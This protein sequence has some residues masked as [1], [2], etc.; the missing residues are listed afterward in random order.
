MAEAAST[1]PDPRTAPRP[2]RG[3]ARAAARHPPVPGLAVG[4]QCASG[5]EAVNLAARLVQDASE[6][7]FFRDNALVRGRGLRFYAGVPLMSATGPRLS[8]ELRRHV[9]YPKTGTM[10]LEY[11]VRR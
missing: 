10:F 3:G 1:P 8:L 5:L 2:S 11:D 7:P 6:N 9:L 4:R